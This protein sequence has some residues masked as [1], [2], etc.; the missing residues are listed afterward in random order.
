[1][2]LTIGLLA[3]HK[4]NTS[5]RVSGDE[6]FVDADV[7]MSVYHT[8]DVVNASD[9]GLSRITA[10]IIT[11][12]SKPDIEGETGL[13]IGCGLGTGDYESSSSFKIVAHNNDGDCQELAN[14]T[15][16]DDLTIRLRVWGLI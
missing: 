8:A 2:T 11:G 14:A 12:Q 16:I 6:Y 13:F 5:P 15:N 7:K 4:G 3:N 1:M 9:L 10:V